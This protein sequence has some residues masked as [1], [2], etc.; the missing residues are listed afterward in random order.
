MKHYSIS[1][2]ARAFGLSRSTLLYYDRIGLLPAGRRTAAGYRIYSERD[3]ER[4]ERICLLRG[5]GLALADV[6]QMLSGET[7]PCA[8]MLEKRLRELR[9]EILNL[10]SQQH[11]VTAMLKNMTKRELGDALDKK[12][13]VE[14]LQSAGMNET[15]MKR[16]H[17][18]FERRAPQAHFDFLLSLGIPENE[19][20]HIQTWSRKKLNS[21]S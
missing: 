1:Q 4:L 9:E 19:A 15:A 3:Y 12:M 17:V 11:L 7:E 16:W 5:A 20:R 6:S 18:E 14:M 8:A 21:L 13:W 10:R 2:L